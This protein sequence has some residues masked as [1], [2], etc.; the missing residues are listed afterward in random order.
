[1]FKI[2]HDQMRYQYHY[3]HLQSNCEEYRSFFSHQLLA[4][5]WND[6]P[7]VITTSSKV[8]DFILKVSEK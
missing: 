1:M 4:K 7:T 6:L 8:N 5:L 2:L 3:I